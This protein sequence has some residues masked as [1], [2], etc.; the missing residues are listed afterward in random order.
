MSIFSLYSGWIA[1][2]NEENMLEPSLFDEPNRAILAAK[3]QLR[4]QAVEPFDKSADR[5]QR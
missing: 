1:L 3:R 4:E 5:R 2:G